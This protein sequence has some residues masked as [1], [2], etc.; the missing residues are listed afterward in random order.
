MIYLGFDTSNYTT[1]VAA[2]GDAFVNTRKLLEVNN[3]Q[4]GHRQ[5]DALFQHIKELPLLF[6]SLCSSIDTKKVSA[7]GVSTKPRNVEGSYMPVFLAGTSFAKICAQSLAVPLYEFSHQ[8]GHIMAGIDSCNAY[9]LMKKPFISVHLSGGT[10][11]ILLSE[12]KNGKFSSQIIGGTKDISAGQLID[13]VGVAMGMGFPAGKEL[14]KKAESSNELLTL[15]VN[16]ENSYI[17]FSGIETKTLSLIN[18]KEHQTIAYSLFVAIAKALCKSLEF[19]ALKYGIDDILTV[20]GVAS[21]TIIKDYLLKNLNKNIYFSS[22]E[23][24][25]D[26]AY[27]IALLTKLCHEKN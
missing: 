8:D 9:N 22:P 15:P 5:S 16:V 4:R 26:N 17:N 7:V 1:S 3:G 2:C 12:Y 25:T 14:E 21:N 10:C 13:R 19:C 20:G 23:F 27:G 24:S 18:E 11:E 6:S